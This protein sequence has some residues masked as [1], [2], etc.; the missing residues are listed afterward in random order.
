MLFRSLIT[1]YQT[2]LDLGYKHIAFN[3]SSI[4]YQEYYH[5]ISER[6]PLYAAMYGRMEFIR[7]LVKIGTINRNVYHHLLGCSLPQ[8]FMCYK[9]WEFIK[10]CDTS[11]PILVGAEGK[12]YDDGGINWKP[13]N[14]LEYYFEM[15]LSERMEDIRFNLKKFRE[16]TK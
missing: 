16:Y 4:A 7:Q 10:S 15:D 3:H 2:L 11:N 14:K 1:T 12:R 5:A 6:R 8:E 13:Q 9:N